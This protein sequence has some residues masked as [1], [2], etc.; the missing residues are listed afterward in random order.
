[1]HINKVK[2]F[3]LEMR[4]VPELDTAEL[5]IIRSIGKFDTLTYDQFYKIFSRSLFRVA[6]SD[7]LASIDEISQ[8]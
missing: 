4:L 5:Q 2:K 7:L 1:M 8:H 3:L 6:L